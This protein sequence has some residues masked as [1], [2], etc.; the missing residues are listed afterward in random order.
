MYFYC[1]IRC[2]VRVIRICIYLR[3][4]KFCI[5]NNISAV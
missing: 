5:N 3:S 2:F 1:S 4:V